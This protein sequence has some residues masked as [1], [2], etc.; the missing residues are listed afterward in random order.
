MTGGMVIW[1]L[2]DTGFS[3]GSLRL[4]SFPELNNWKPVA[5]TKRLLCSSCS[6]CLS[7]LS[8]PSMEVIS[9]WVSSLLLVSSLLPTLGLVQG[10]VCSSRTS[11]R[12]K[13]ASGQTSKLATLLSFSPV[14]CPQPRHPALISFLFF[15]VLFLILQYLTQHLSPILAPGCH[16]RNE[17]QYLSYI[18]GNPQPQSSED[19]PNISNV[20]QYI[21]LQEKFPKCVLG[22]SSI[23]CQ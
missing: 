13:K 20:T 21:F 17:C 14:V 5:P 19:A 7:S 23:G 9:A 18:W 6:A 3:K 15:S 2:K 8:S 16:H 11:G 10:S 1:L 12:R 22:N 4:P